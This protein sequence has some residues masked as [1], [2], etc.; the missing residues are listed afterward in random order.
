LK[1][2][3]R[4]PFED[5]AIVELI[6]APME[7]VYGT[8]MDEVFKALGSGHGQPARRIRGAAR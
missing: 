8:L 5:G 4:L 6:K 3:K 1:A 2:A 7:E